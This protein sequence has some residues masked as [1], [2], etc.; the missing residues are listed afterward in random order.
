MITIIVLKIEVW[1]YNVVM[2]PKDRDVDEIAHS[3]SPI[4]QK[5]NNIM[6]NQ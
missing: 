1:F 2:S 3:D 4:R 5:P 6:L